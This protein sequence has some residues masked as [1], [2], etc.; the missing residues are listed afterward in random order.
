MSWRISLIFKPQS[1]ANVVLEIICLLKYIFLN[2]PTINTSG[3]SL[4]ATHF[5]VLGSLE[6]NPKVG[7]VE[8]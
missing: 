5:C 6:Y 2:E 4:L 7:L 3:E 8:I 1:E